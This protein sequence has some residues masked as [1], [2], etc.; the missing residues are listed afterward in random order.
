VSAPRFFVS[1]VFAL[2]DTPPLAPEDA[3]KLTLVLRKGPG[4][5]L[6]IVDSSGRLYAASLRIA[7]D[8]ALALLERELAAPPATS[9][10]LTLAQGLPKGQKMDYVIEKATELGIERIVA[11]TSSRTVGEGSR[12]GKLERWRRLAKSAAQQCGRVDLPAVEGPIPFDALTAAIPTYDAAIVPW[13]LAPRIPLHDRLPTLI[14]AATSVLI[15]IG[16]EG[17]LSESEAHALR[18]AGAHL[19]SLG[20]RIL[21][22]ETAGLVIC[23]ALLYAS[24]DI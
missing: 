18:T 4:D 12:E 24:G 3:R 8:A 14:T 6:E 1:G 9:L 13:E 2:G 21:R 20:P 5:G 19:V 23:S 7:G 22:T 10:R 11:F 17:G 16:P 15:A